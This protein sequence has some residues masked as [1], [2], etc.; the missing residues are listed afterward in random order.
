MVTQNP[1]PGGGWLCRKSLVPC[2]LGSRPAGLST[3]PSLQQAELTLLFPAVAQK[4]VALRKK[5]QLAIGPCKSLP[6]SPSHSAV[7]AASIPAVHINQV[8]SPL[9]GTPW[10]VCLVCLFLSPSASCLPL[11]ISKL[12]TLL[13][14]PGLC[15]LHGWP[16]S[17]LFLVVT[18]PCPSFH[19]VHPTVFSPPQLF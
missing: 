19:A 5:Q 15:S 13:V 4:V 8:R 16:W 9:P 3:S 12:V 11:L 2:V 6:N 10:P 14:A 18:A 17:G 7:S 1:E